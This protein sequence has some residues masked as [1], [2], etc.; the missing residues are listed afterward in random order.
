MDT[1]QGAKESGGLHGLSKQLEDILGSERLPPSQVQALPVRAYLD[2]TVVP[3]LMEGLK[4]V[5]RERPANPS[6]SIL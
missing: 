1:S 4:A 2:Q 3:V 6:G 5:A